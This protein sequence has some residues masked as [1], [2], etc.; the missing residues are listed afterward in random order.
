MASTD[1]RPLPLK[2]TAFRLYFTAYDSS[3]VPVTAFTS[4]DSEV[5]KDGAAYSDCTAEA[6][7]VGHGSGYIDLTSTEMN[8]DHVSYSFECTEGSTIIQLYPAEDADIRTRVVEMS[9]AV[10][11]AILDEVCPEPSSIPAA[12]AMT[13][14]EAAAIAVMAIL[15]PNTATSTTRVLKKRDG[16]TV[17]TATR[18]DD[19]TTYNQGA[20]A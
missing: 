20:M 4:P 14:R 9:T 1:A 16:T 10:V 13:L 11:D 5:S 3:G 12:A 6:T 15:S 2:N 8:A 7:Y 19:D 17:G 18:S